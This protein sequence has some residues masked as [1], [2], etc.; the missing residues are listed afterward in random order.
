[1]LLYTD[2]RNSHI[3]RAH[4]MKTGS[5][6]HITRT[7]NEIQLPRFTYYINR[8]KFNRGAEET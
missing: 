8:Q 3:K 6:Q 2:K 4:M 5:L 1:M 7:S